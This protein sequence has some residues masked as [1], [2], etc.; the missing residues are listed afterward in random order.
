QAADDTADVLESLNPDDDVD[1]VAWIKQQPLPYPAAG[2]SGA[3]HKQGDGGAALGSS[4]AHA[5]GQAQRHDRRQR[6][7]A[8]VDWAD[9]ARLIQRGQGATPRSLLPCR[10]GMEP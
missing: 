5:C 6:V 9:D 3:V 8:D 1:S 2:C 4:P 7:G 10:T